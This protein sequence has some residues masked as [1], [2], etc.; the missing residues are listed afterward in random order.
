MKTID[1][2]GKAYV[3]VNE[4]IMY[5]REHYPT[6]NII[7]EIVS[8][9]DGVCIMKVLITVDNIVRAT[10]HA[11]EKEDSSFINKTSYIENCETSA[12]GRALG[13][14]GIGIDVSI[15]TAEEVTNAIENQKP[16]KATKPTTDQMD[17]LVKLAETKNI[18]YEDLH[19]Y[20][21]TKFKIGFSNIKSD[22][23]A[24]LLAHLKEIKV[25]E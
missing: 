10:G 12:V 2:K 1:I 22:N 3:Q 8:I 7:T 6:G 18:S 17:K 16:T 13:L 11:Y 5:F 4:R 14:F 21:T 20:C 9:A 23:Y 15:A 19:K 25:K 24:K